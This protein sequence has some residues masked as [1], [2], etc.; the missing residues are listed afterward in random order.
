MP[1]AIDLTGRVYGRLT[2]VSLGETRGAKRHW[3]CLCKCGRMKQIAG[4]SLA[5]GTVLSCGCLHAELLAHRN[6]ERTRHGH[7]ID[8]RSSA[9]YVA[10]RSMRARCY[11]ARDIEYPNYGARGITV[12]ERWRTSFESFLEDMG[13][14]PS[15]KHTLDRYPDNDGNY[16]PSNCR[17]AT[18][19]EQSNNKRTNRRL[20]LN[21][22]TQTLAEWAREC[23]MGADAIAWRIKRGWSIERAITERTTHPPVGGDAVRE[24][25]ASSLAGELTV[26]LAAR[27][28]VSRSTI[29]RIVCRTSRSRV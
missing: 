13:P 12:C 6:R 8:R 9:E 7:T 29:R 20:T 19:S 27:Y 5:R 1:R 22:K 15:P 23:G 18:C 25:R 10:W 4:A 17:W 2:V 24:I 26:I 14:R 21:G 16:E 3:D 11:Y 28:S